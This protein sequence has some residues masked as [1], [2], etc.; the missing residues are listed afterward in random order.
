VYL[1][2]RPLQEV[3]APS[4]P[5]IG[6]EPRADNQVQPQE[7]AAPS[8]P[9][10]A[11][12]PACA[13]AA[14]TT[15]ATASHVAQDE[16]AARAAI[17]NA[18]APVLFRDSSASRSRGR[19]LA[20]AA[21]LGALGI[22]VYFAYGYF[23]RI[24]PRDVAPRPAATRDAK[25]RAPSDKGTATQSA[26]SMEA[27]KPGVAG[28]APTA[29]SAVDRGAAAAGPVSVTAGEAAGGKGSRGTDPAEA[30]AAKPP[31]PLD[32]FIAKPE[33][34]RR[35][36][37]QEAAKTAAAGTQGGSSRPASKDGAATCTDAL[38]ALGLCTQENTQG[39]KP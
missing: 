11:V 28:D 22:A 20:W 4:P 38:A 12:T 36:Q 35:A 27:A 34:E 32:I 8:P 2:D 29:A 16:E 17:E 19:P 9:E 24:Q 23:Q 14:E 26:T 25:D 18:A 31:P 37:A 7:V 39:R 13:P 3:A 5:A 1:A 6:I 10:E 33:L 21:V 15:T 30:G